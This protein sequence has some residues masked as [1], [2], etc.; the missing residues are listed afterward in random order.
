MNSKMINL[1][2]LIEDRRFIKDFATSHKDD[3]LRRNKY[4]S[5]DHYLAIWRWYMDAKGVW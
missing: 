5:E 1:Y 3:F 4:L 2:D